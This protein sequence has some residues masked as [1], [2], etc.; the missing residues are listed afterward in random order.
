MALQDNVNELSQV[1]NGGQVAQRGTAH[2]DYRPT[3]PASN[4]KRPT[5]SKT[6][7]AKSATK[8]SHVIPLTDNELGQF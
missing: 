5:L 2:Q 1:V 8:P 6:N 7:K 3:R 4:L